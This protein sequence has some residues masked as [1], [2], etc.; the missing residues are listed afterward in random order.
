MISFFTGVKFT[1]EMM[2]RI[3]MPAKRDIHVF[4]NFG[5]CVKSIDH[6]ASRFFVGISRVDLF[7]VINSK[8]TFHKKCPI[9]N[10]SD[11]KIGT[12]S[13]KMELGINELHFGRDLIGENIE[14]YLKAFFTYLL[15]L[16]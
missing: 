12:L 8:S 11:M 10:E 5:F 13:V 6:Q 14:N 2:Q 9:I 7:D 16:S 3:N 15:I 4:I 1:R